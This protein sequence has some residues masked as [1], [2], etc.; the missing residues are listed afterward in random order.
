MTTEMKKDKLGFPMTVAELQ[1]ADGYTVDRI[2]AEL[3]MMKSFG[4]EIPDDAVI[5]NDA[6][7]VM[8]KETPTH[9]YQRI[10]NVIQLIDGDPD[11]DFTMV[12]IQWYTPKVVH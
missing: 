9:D 1:K 8:F 2:K 3:T 12:Y 4:E 6:T 5:S 11:P 7:V 10:T